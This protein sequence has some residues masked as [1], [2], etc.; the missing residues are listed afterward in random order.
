MAAITCVALACDDEDISIVQPDAGVGGTGGSTAG[1]G[2]SA[3]SSVAGTGG[4][5]T[6]GSAGMAGTAG[7]GGSGGSSGSAGTGGTDPG[8]AG[9]DADTTTDPDGGD[10]GPTEPTIAEICLE[11]C[12]LKGAFASETTGDAG[13]N[14]AAVDVNTCAT[15][16]A[17]G[18][19]FPLPD[20]P[21]YKAANSC[22]ATENAWF[23]DS[24]TTVFPSG[25]GAEQGN[26]GSCF[27]G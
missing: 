23:C 9:P 5:N 22:F 8:D 19:D 4:A 16:C 2:G 25:C 11:V 3:G 6:A 24:G 17:N 13:P 1:S 21:A 26:L 20:C 12:T 7:T 15:N 14:C 27:G 18:T 10:S